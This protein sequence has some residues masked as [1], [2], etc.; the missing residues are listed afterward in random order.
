MDS[1]MITLREYKTFFKFNLV[2]TLYVVVLGIGLSG[3]LMLLELLYFHFVEPKIPDT[4][5]PFT[6]F[7]SKVL[8]PLV[9]FFILKESFDWCFGEYSTFTIRFVKKGQWLRYF[10]LF[11]VQVALFTL[12]LWT[13]YVGS[14]YAFG[15]FDIRSFFAVILLPL[16]YTP[17][18]L[19][20]F[21]SFFKESYT[22]TYK[23]NTPKL[24]ALSA[25]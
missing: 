4:Y 20:L 1:Q 23:D 14:I 24:D 6:W 9:S 15:S 25:Q 2:W 5:L 22:I 7:L 12:V 11:I 16:F 13:L 3:F 10:A 19:K 8:S 21:F 17:F 18:L